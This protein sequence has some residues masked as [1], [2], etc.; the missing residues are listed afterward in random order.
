MPVTS[1]NA[2]VETSGTPKAS[3]VA[4]IT[5]CAACELRNVCS[6]YEYSVI[7]GVYK[8]FQPLVE[9]Q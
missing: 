7:Y 5:R 1:T 4:I 2:S 6:M 9:A 8:E 3:F